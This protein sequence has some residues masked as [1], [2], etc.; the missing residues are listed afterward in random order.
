MTQRLLREMPSKGELRKDARLVTKEAANVGRRVN[1]NLLASGEKIAASPSPQQIAL[2]LTL[3]FSTAPIRYATQYSTYPTTLASPFRFITE[4]RTT[5][6]VNQNYF[7]SAVS[8]SPLQ[9]AV[10]G[11]QRPADYTGS[12]YQFYF[13][14]TNSNLE[15]DNDF[16]PRAF[17][18]IF[19][20]NTDPIS[21]PIEPIWSEFLDGW[22]RHDER[23]FG[24]DGVGSRGI[25]LDRRENADFAFTDENGNLVAPPPNATIA[26]D[27]WV[28]G[29]WQYVSQLAFDVTTTGQWGWPTGTNIMHY[30]TDEAGYRRFRLNFNPVALTIYYVVVRH[31]WTS[32]TVPGYYPVPSYLFGIHAMPGAYEKMR[33]VPAIRT[34]AVSMLATNLTPQLYRGGLITGVQAPEAYSIGDIVEE[35]YFSNAESFASWNGAVTKNADKGMYAFHRPTGDKCFEMNNFCTTRRGAV[36]SLSNPIQP[37]GGWLL[38]TSQVASTDGANVSR[39]AFTFS[40]AIEFQT[41][42]TWYP[43][44]MS[45]TS[46][47]NWLRAIELVRG[48]EQFDENPLHFKDIVNAITSTARRAAIMSPKIVKALSTFL[49]GASNFQGLA[50]ELSRLA[51]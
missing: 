28:D 37:C 18:E 29:H 19:A 32:A 45:S 12:A 27:R 30:V 11:Q 20:P 2:A 49:P 46:T 4:S 34:M 15:P 43:R 21:A 39:F 24:A 17:F 13:N 14:D 10:T 8:R 35:C 40:A 9:F 7:F 16:R 47:A 3:P 41:T 33:S 25:F 6:D 36:W 51:M 42:D 48:C 50:D 23:L 1:R 31:G 22:P 5:S 26:V 44:E 38:F